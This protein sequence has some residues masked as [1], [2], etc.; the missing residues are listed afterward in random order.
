MKIGTTRDICR[1][2]G[3]QPSRNDLLMINTKKGEIM[4]L[5]CL[6]IEMLISSCPDEEPLIPLIVEL[7]SS[8]V[9]GLKK[10]EKGTGGGM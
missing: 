8:S 2:R 6:I 9:V 10:K 3:K 4:S 7:T 5:H 1:N